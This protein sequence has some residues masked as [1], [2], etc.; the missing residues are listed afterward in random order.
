LA[1][2][3]DLAASFAEIEGRGTTNVF[4]EMKRILFEQGV[5]EAIAYVFSQRASILE[6]V[7]VR[8]ATAHKR[9]RADLHPLLKT[10]GL[11]EAKGQAA[12][13]RALYSDIFDVEPDWPEALHAFFWFLA[14]Q[15][16][17]A[18]VRTTL[19][20][21]LREYEEA[22]RQA[23]RLAEAD[24]THSDWQRDLSVSYNKLGDVAVAQG[25]LEEAAAAYGDG[26]AI[27][28]RLAEAD[29][30]HSDWQRDLSVSY[31][32]LGDV[33]EKQKK[34]KDARGYWNKAFEVLSDIKIR[35]VHISPEDQHYLEILR[36]KAGLTKD[37]KLKNGDP[38]SNE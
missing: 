9:N 10:A 23:K 14:G 15:G 34:D 12:E 35:G 7:K 11:Y 38:L 33:A 29:P 13:A 25:K 36:S 3:D 20:Q 24:P 2:I 8:A 18:L 26:L 17:I 6:R 28:K 30:T 27:A 21:A 16:D 19:N 37:L 22:H 5:D 32:K 31:N 4:Q 1:R